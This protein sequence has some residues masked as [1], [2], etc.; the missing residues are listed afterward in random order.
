MIAFAL[1][2]PAPAR[3]S[4]YVALYGPECGRGAVVRP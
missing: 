2:V 3:V 4:I 1:H